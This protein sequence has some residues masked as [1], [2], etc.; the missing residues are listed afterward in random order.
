[1]KLRTIV[2]GAQISLCAAGLL[3]GGW[4]AKAAC[5]EPEQAG[6]IAAVLPSMAQS[7]NDTGA[8]TRGSERDHRRS[9][10][11]LWHVTFVKSDGSPFYQSFDL[12][13]SD[14]TEFETA[15]ASPLNGNVCVGVWRETKGGSV[16]LHHVGWHFEGGVLT[17]TFT[18]DETNTVASDGKTYKGTFLYQRYDLAGNLLLQVAGTL[19][20]DRITV[21]AGEEDSS[22]EG[23]AP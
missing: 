19:T 7:S 16:Q 8:L 21:E 12:W 15:S 13:H 1:M 6:G 9:I 18:L 17:A 20:A 4:S 23:S 3:C 5:G 10:V 14:R 11:G 2:R 22:T